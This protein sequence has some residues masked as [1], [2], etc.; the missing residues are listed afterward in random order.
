MK[1]ATGKISNKND[2]ML[3]HL[4][5]SPCESFNETS[6]IWALGAED[7]LVY[8]CSLHDTRPYALPGTVNTDLGL[9]MTGNTL[10]G[11]RVSFPIESN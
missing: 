9:L 1:A 7:P 8:S 11:C 6:S 3:D 2:T 4:Q 5:V 10:T